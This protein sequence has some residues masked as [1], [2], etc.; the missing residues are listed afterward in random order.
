M[1]GFYQFTAMFKRHS[2]FA[3]AEIQLEF[4]QTPSLSLSLPGGMTEL[5]YHFS[6]PTSAC[7][8]AEGWHCESGWHAMTVDQLPGT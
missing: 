8:K 4:T 6:N 3:K 7:L 5:L 2:F 1:G